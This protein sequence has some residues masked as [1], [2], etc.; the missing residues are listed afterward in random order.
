MGGKRANSGPERAIAAIAARQHGVLSSTQLIDAGL[1]PRAIDCRVDAGRLHRLHRGVYA[2]GHRALSHRG[3][4][5]AA[6]LACGPGAVLSHADAARLWR[7][8]PVEEHPGPVH[9][10]VPGAGGRRRRSGIVAHRSQTLAQAEVTRRHSIPVTRP[11]RTI[12]DLARV[13]PKERVAA[14]ADRARLLGL[15]VDRREA[16]TRSS[17][18]RRFLARCRRH[19]LPP[20]EVNVWIGPDRVDFLWRSERLVVE[21]DGWETHR[22]RAAFE[23]DRARDARLRLADYEV[24]RVTDRQLHEEPERVAATVRALLARRP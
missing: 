20:P 16:P 15:R 1:T 10:T 12:A 2:V 13:L 24:V 8:L 9:V 17:L 19:R 11:A 21:T 22:T 6:V 3:R 14:A 7:L 23:A 4:W 18:E 5:L